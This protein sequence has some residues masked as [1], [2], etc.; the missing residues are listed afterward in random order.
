MPPHQ[1]LVYDA[2]GRDVSGVVGPLYEGDSLVLSCEVRGGKLKSKFLN[3]KSNTISEK[4][5]R[6]L[7]NYAKSKIK[8]KQ[9]QTTQ[10]PSAERLNE[11][12]IHNRKNINYLE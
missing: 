7:M 4:K 1:I 12:R 8:Y 5:T 9:K 6:G 11:N 2:S 10:T 3:K